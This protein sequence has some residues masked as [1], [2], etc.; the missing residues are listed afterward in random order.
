MLEKLYRA[1]RE[2]AEPKAINLC[3]RT[4]TTHEVYPV[5]LPKPIPLTVRTLSGLVGYLQA[6]VDDLSHDNLLCHV[7]SPT[8]VVLYS[9]LQGDFDDRSA[10]LVAELQQLQLKFNTFMDAETFNIHL[11]SCFTDPEGVQATDRGLVLKY[12][13]NIKSTVEN[14]LSD[15]GVSQQVTVK[16]GIASV[17]NAV[18]PNPVLLRPFRTFTE[19]VQPVS[20]FV[21]RCRQND[22]CGMQ[23]CLVEADGGAWRSTAM[24]SIKLYLENEIPWLN[25][26]A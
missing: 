23:F 11:Q 10:Y 20:S 3:D 26:I 18:L 12:I 6:N 17:G 22:E 8:G 2:D 13:A 25:V 16:T 9:G 7:E 19:V 1:I 24:A 5:H 14:G 15:D 4:Y 21:F